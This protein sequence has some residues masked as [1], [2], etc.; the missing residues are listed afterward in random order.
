M[1]VVIVIVLFVVVG[2]WALSSLSRSKLKAQ[3]RA[4]CAFCGKRLKKVMAGYAETCKACGRDQPW[5]TSSRA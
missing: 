1:T 3:G 2:M 4:K 5:A